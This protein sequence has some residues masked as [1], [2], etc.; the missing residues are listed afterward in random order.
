MLLLLPALLAGC[1]QGPIPAAQRDF[2][3]EADTLLHGLGPGKTCRNDRDC[4]E[5]QA[6]AVCT[7]GTCFGLLTTDERV[8]RALLVERLG[9]ADRP[10]QTAAIK[11]LL[12]VLGN[13][14][15]RRS[16]R[17]T[18]WRRGRASRGMR[19]SWMRF[20]FWLPPKKRR[21]R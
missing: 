10:V 14:M 6:R 17:S 9:L 19:K 18:G 11:P 16:R 2:A 13:D 4:Q 3:L 12:A 15:A 8:T 7:L 1:A 21:W 5:G 20:G